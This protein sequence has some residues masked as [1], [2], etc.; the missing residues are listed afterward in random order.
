[1]T[2]HLLSKAF[3]SVV[4]IRS[5]LRRSPCRPL[6]HELHVDYFEE[7]IPLLVSHFNQ[8]TDKIAVLIFAQRS[9]S[10]EGGSSRK[11]RRNDLIENS[12]VHVSEFLAYCQVLIVTRTPS[13]VYYGI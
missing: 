12:I 5:Y 10:D 6:T 9:N 4:R 3:T 7:A 2:R 13:S 11:S 1:M 8:F